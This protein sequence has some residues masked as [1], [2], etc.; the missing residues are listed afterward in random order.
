MSNTRTPATFDE[1]LNSDYVQGKLKEYVHLKE[2]VRVALAERKVWEKD[3]KNY[4]PRKAP[5]LIRDA[6]SVSFENTKTGVSETLLRGVENLPMD[7]GYKIC[8]LLDVKGD[9]PIIPYV[10]ALVRKCGL[11]NSQENKAPAPG[12]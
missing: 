8:S 11:D 12:Q 9:Q 7:A 6:A 5:E 2:Y 1:K 3:P 4:N 10:E